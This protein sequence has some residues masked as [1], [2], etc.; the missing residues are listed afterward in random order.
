MKTIEVGKNEEGQRLTRV[1]SKYL[2]T[3]PDSFLYRMLRKKN[4]VLNDKRATG[5]ERLIL[6][7]IIKI[8]LSD[9]TVLKFGGEVYT[10]TDRSQAVPQLESLI[11]YEDDQIVIVDKPAGLLSQRA[12]EADVSVVDMVVD[13][14]LRNGRI[15]QEQLKT[16]RPG[17]VSRLDRNT[18]GLVIA[19]KTLSAL[20]DLNYLVRTHALRKEYAAFAQGRLSDEQILEGYW[21]KDSKTNTV[22]IL[23]TPS[24][25]A[26]RVL[27]HVMPAGFGTDPGTKETVSYILVELLTGKGH[28]IR[29]H[30][31]AVGHP[32]VGDTKYGACAASFRTGQLL[33]AHKITFP[34]DHLSET[35]LAALSGKTF[36]APLPADFKSAYTWYQIQE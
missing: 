27:T 18:S 25:H 14:L 7:D 2:R 11:I 22:S 34:E 19:G 16:F 13:Y 20:Q 9:D 28:Q 8:Y 31:A 36:S 5:K 6:G 3:A 21:S 30:L 15:D 17:I 26:K 24:E 10:P 33:H 1:L 12:Q 29:A 4:I 35:T 32:L 23:K